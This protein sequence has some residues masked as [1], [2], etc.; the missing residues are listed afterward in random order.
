M[1][2]AKNKNDVN[3][4]RI[5]ER[6]E[7]IVGEEGKEGV[8]TCRVSDIKPDH[9]VISRPVFS[10]GKS[11]LANNRFIRV[12]FTRADAAYSF[13]ARITTTNSESTD[14]KWLV[15]LGEIKR[16][17]RRRFV[18]VEK[19]SKVGYF[20]LKKPIT[21]KLE[22]KPSDFKKSHTIN[23]SAG[24][25]LMPVDEDDEITLDSLLI[26][27]FAKS[28]L[29]S[30]N[31]YVIAIVRQDRETEEKQRVVGVEFILNDNLK[32]Y[33]SR[34]ALSH[35]PEEARHFTLNIQNDLVSEMFNEQ[36]NLRQ[37]GLI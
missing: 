6:L 29:K 18:R 12:N 25:L 30:L 4:I 32:L 19:V 17:Q 37:K 22:L 31:S 26:L 10:Y 27:N 33:L 7:L 20:I 8:Y 16:L 11:L 3:S 15:D 36:L 23:I 21:E 28:G 1:T 13:A 9:L 24:G 34:E 2:L 14:D 5:W 35:I